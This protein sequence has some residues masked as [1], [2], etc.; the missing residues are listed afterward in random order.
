MFCI[1]LLSSSLWLKKSSSRLSFWT[2]VNLFQPNF[3]SSSFCNW[4]HSH[5]YYGSSRLKS[6]KGNVIFILIWKKW[7]VFTTPTLEPVIADSIGIASA[8]KEFTQPSSELN[9]MLNRTWLSLKTWLFPSYREKSFSFSSLRALCNLNKGVCVYVCIY[10]YV[11]ACAWG[12]GSWGL[13][14][15]KMGSCSGPA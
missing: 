6:Y 15:G 1:I 8:S 11:C 4:L 3:A 2:E 7:L 5:M 13:V 9:I 12:Q 10:V 14:L